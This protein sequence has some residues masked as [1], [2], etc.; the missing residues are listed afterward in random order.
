MTRGIQPATGTWLLGERQDR[1]EPASGS[2]A[3]A[4]DRVEVLCGP[5]AVVRS[6][7]WAHRTLCAVG[8]REREV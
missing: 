3:T 7:G 1:C 4:A 6:V 8:F 5:H 2:T